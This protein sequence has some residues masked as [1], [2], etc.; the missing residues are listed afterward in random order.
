MRVARL[1][2]TERSPRPNLTRRARVQRPQ[3]DRPYTRGPLRHRDY[4]VP[5]PAPSDDPLLSLP[6]Q[7][8]VLLSAHENYLGDRTCTHQVAIRARFFIRIRYGLHLLYAVLVHR[9]HHCLSTRDHRRVIR[10]IW[11]PHNFV[12]LLR[13]HHDVDPLLM[14]VEH[15]RVS[16]SGV[17]RVHNT[18][19]IG[20]GRR[21][22]PQGP[23]LPLYTHL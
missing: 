9:L 11:T 15:R 6:T 23:L 3:R 8:R 13:L 4:L 12:S 1:Q 19:H 16:H 7:V 10:H 20:K 14:P 18:D 17:R 21:L 5:D 22:H 2:V